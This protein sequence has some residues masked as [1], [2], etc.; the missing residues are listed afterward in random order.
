MP[1]NDDGFRHGLTA[2]TVSE[3]ANREMRRR[4]IDRELLE[5]VL[6]APEQTISVSPT[7]VVMQSRHARRERT[8]LLRVFV[9]IDR[10]PPVVVTAYLTSKVD[11]Y[12]GEET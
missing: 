12:W 2:W 8:Y 9:D 7:R 10:N 5:T 4:N 6:S 11:K 1:Q 3:H